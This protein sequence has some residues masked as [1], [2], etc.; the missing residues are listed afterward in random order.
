VTETV[1]SESDLRRLVLQVLAT[2]STDDWGSIRA[3]VMKRV[4]AEDLGSIG[5]SGEQ[6]VNQ[7]IVSLL[8]DQLITVGARDGN[9]S[10]RA[11]PSIMLT[12]FGKSWA[13]D[14]ARLR[15]PDGYG[16]LLSEYA[17]GVEAAT[18]EYALEAFRCLQQNLL[19]A[20]AVMIGAAAEREVFRL[21]RAILASETEEATKKLK[22]ALERGRLPTLFQEIRTSIEAAI[23]RDAMPFSVHQGSTEHLL[24]FQE[25]IRVQRND[26]VHAGGTTVSKEKVFLAIQTFPVAVGAIDRLRSWFE[27]RGH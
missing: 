18:V 27:A 23:R 17:P 24:S 9:Y 25:M 21:G 6:R 13:A 12:E 1:V 15:D 14:I 2:V 26:A 7:V 11:W 8:I 3:E 22:E 16:A 10:P 4:N 20:C 5:R 19:F